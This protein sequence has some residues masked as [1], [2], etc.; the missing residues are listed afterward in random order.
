[1]GNRRFRNL[2]NLRRKNNKNGQNTFT[3]MADSFATDVETDLV[4]D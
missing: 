2:T 4:E 1:M 3:I